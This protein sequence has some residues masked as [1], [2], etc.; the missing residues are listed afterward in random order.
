PQY[1]DVTED[2]DIGELDEVHDDHKENDN[3]LTVTE[4]FSEP[5]SPTIRYEVSES[6]DL[7]DPIRGLRDIPPAAP[8]PP[9]QTTINPAA[10][11]YRWE[12]DDIEGSDDEPM[13]SNSPIRRRSTRL[14]LNPRNTPGAATPKPSV[15]FEGLF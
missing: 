6:G 4:T 1:L 11:D 10:F 13:P 5:S 15:N 2:R 14:S 12:I 8:S 7:V 9:A 3:Q